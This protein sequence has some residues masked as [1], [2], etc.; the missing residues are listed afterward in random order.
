MFVCVCSEVFVKHDGSLYT[1]GDVMYREKLA[2]TLELIAS[3]DG[4]WDLYNGRLAQTMLEDLHD[5]GE[6]SIISTYSCKRQLLKIAQL[7][8]VEIFGT[9][10]RSGKGKRQFV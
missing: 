7:H 4:A 5:I 1:E 2:D 3:D 6:I 9:G 8:G 10:H